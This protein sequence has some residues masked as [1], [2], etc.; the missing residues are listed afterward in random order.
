MIKKT[1]GPSL[2]LM[3]FLSCL[4]WIICIYTA[5]QTIS[6]TPTPFQ[7][8]VMLDLDSRVGKTSN[9]CMSM[10]L[11]DFYDVN[12]H[13]STRLTLH[14]INSTDV[15]TAVISAYGLLKDVRVQVIVGPQKS[16][17]AEFVAGLGNKTHVPVVSFSASSP[18]LSHS[19]MPYFVRMTQNDTYQL[20]AIASIV[21]LFGWKEVVLIY[22]GTDYGH[23][24]IPYFTDAFQRINVRVPHRSVIAP[25]AK[26]DEIL[27]ELHKLSTMS[28]RVFIVHISATSLGL[29]FFQNVKDVELMSEGNAWIITEELTNMLGSLNNSVIDL[30][31]GVLGVKPYIPRSRDLN[32][33]RA[34]LMR[35]NTFQENTATGHNLDL[36][37]LHA[38]DTIWALAMAAEKVCGNHSCRVSKMDKTATYLAEIEKSEMG[39][40]LLKEILNSEFEGLSGDIRLVDG[41]LQPTIFQILNVVGTGEREIGFWIPKVG[42]P[43]LRPIM[44]P[45][46]VMDAPNGS[47]VPTKKLKIGVPVKCSFTEFVKVEVDL[48]N[49]G[50]KVTG[51]CID[52]FDAVMK[53]LP[54]VVP[55]EYVPFRK[56]NGDRAGNYTNL[57]HQVFLQKYDAVVGDV[58]ITAK[59][60][61]SVDFSRP[62]T[63]GGIA[64]LVPNAYEKSNMF[65]IFFAPFTWGVWFTSGTKVVDGLKTAPNFI[66]KIFLAPFCFFMIWIYCDLYMK[67]LNDDSGQLMAVDVKD[68]IRN[69]DYVGYQKDSLVEKVL[70]ELNFDESKLRIYDSLEEYEEALDK[71]SKNGGVAAIF[72]EMPYIKLLLTKFGY[73]YRTVGPIYQLDGFGFVFPRGSHLTADVS[74]AILPVLE[75]KLVQIETAWLG[76][77]K[78]WSDQNKDLPPNTIPL[79]KMWGIFAIVGVLLVIVL[80]LFLLASIDKLSATNPPV[81]PNVDNVEA[82]EE[83]VM[84][85]DAPQAERQ[86]QYVSDNDSET[87]Y[88]ASL[89][90]FLEL[91]IV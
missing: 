88:G 2:K 21:Q 80:V 56:P 61:L 30:M 34:R 84:A 57:I 3:F 68:L 7:V 59:R 69:G 10:A 32:N 85:V 79:K 29:R 55:Y 14:T 44:W 42:I 78:A 64:M 1:C 46:E 51:Y 4:L 63:N 33:F 16:E 43:H 81:P 23:G 12:N 49:N 76:S 77:E 20:E 65:M 8:G 83:N 35:M 60:S 47:V 48:S 58:T 87:L 13:Y 52:V 91:A 27:K 73:K 86:R 24:I 6:I 71:G 36:F 5:A 62:Y 17:Q 54:Y 67:N 41:Q 38:Y 18:S 50:T 89:P 72:D 45:G 28:T 75:E 66:L 9:T 90:A 19:Q 31:R 37:C 39:S 22:E 74:R 26:D 70:M 82:L 15:V 53:L 25:S 40:E 11:S